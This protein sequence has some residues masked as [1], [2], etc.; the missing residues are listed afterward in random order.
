MSIADTYSDLI[1]EQV[2]KNILDDG[3]V[4][5]I[6]EIDSRYKAFVNNRDLSAPL[7]DEGQAEVIP[8]EKFSAAKYNETNLE[9]ARD[10]TVLYKELLAITD[11]SIKSFDRWRTETL[12]MQAQIRALDTRITNLLR[13]QIEQNS[14]F[15]ADDFIDSSKTDVNNTTAFLNLNEHTVALY[16]SNN[17]PTKIILN[18]IDP[19]KVEFNLLSRNDL[20]NIVNITPIINAF[21]DVNSF[22]QT[23]VLVNNS[24]KP[25]TAELKI[26]LNNAVV[27]VSKITFTIH[28][29]NA[30]NPIQITPMISTDGIN[31]SALNTSNITVSVDTIGS[32]SFPSTDVLVVKFIMTKTGYDTL[33]NNNFVY[34]FGAQDISF[35][36]ENFGTDSQTFYSTALSGLDTD[37]NPIEFDSVELEVCERIPDNTSIDYFISALNSP[38][39]TPTWISIDQVDKDP[40]LHSKKISFGNIDNITLH[41][42]QVSFDSSGSTNL[43][44]P[45]ANFD[46]I[47]LSSGSTITTNLTAPNIRYV[48]VNSNERI[49]NYQI[50]GSID[51]VQD[52]VEIFR[53]VGIRGNTDLVRNIQS[54]WTF[55]EPY[56]ISN[57]EIT[58]Q[59]GLLIDFGDQQ[60]ILDNTPAKG[61]TTVLNGI[62]NIKIHK[63]NWINIPVGL[64]TIED[65]KSNDP[66][67]PFNHKY[68]V[69][70]YDLLSPENPYLG[71]DIF[72]GYYMTQVSIYDLSNNVQSDDYS[73]FAIDV[74][75]DIPSIPKGPSTIFVVKSNENYSDFLDE[76]FTIR[77]DVKNQLYKYIKFQAQLNTQDSGVTPNLDGYK[78]KI[79]T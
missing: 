65:L 70:G 4:L 17:N 15:I 78:L 28:S 54:G 11:D 20:Q 42:S 25:I 14:N 63:N 37:N 18:D 8:A 31:F 10:L 21:Q 13:T 66:L 39:D 27:P 3:I 12:S 35:Y 36:N 19:S 51:V 5:S 76:L 47:S 69:E 45:G 75:A 79:S 24:Q 26:Q 30:G 2:I 74:D 7:F 33:D 71:A 64:T 73:K 9:I 56:Y 38:T 1:L 58:N 40:S 55:A 44:N 50:D 49:L 48:L 60:I 43:I 68:L 77:F 57:I 61:R 67:F 41:G 34:E 22:W 59:N 29:S 72:A 62:H 46:L 53:N 52:S 6:A 16:T 32:W 23:Q